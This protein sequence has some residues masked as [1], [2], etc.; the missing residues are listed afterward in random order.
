MTRLKGICDMVSTPYIADVGTDHG[1]VP[2]MLIQDQK[3]LHAFV[4]DISPKCVDKARGNLKGLKKYVTFLCGNGLGVFTGNML[5]NFRQIT[6]IITG[7]GGIEIIKILST[8]PVQFD[9]YIL[10]AQRNIFDLKDYLFLHNFE[11]LQDKIVK[12]DKM[13][14]NLLLVKHSKDAPTLTQKELYFG[15]DNIKT[16]PQ[17][18]VEYLNFLQERYNKLLNFRKDDIMDKYLMLCDIL[19]GKNV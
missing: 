4:T 10:G 1:F 8:S 11:I 14:Y 7:M 15:K 17:D 5:Q 12:E 3:I 16:M 13:F 19:G 18:F 6:A 9:Y 2:Q